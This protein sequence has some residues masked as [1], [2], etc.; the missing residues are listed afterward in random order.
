MSD[1]IPFDRDV[2]PAMKLLRS[3]IQP[4]I[5]MLMQAA[6]RNGADYIDTAISVV[7]TL[8]EEQAQLL[9]CI[10]D[11]EYRRKVTVL[12]HERLLDAVEI[13]HCEAMVKAG[14]SGRA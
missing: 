8:A 6:E 9:A 3:R 11:H 12:L 7:A 14:L 13:A 4:E 2:T 5:L 1:E 10:V